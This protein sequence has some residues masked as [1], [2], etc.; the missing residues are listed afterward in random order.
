[1][2][3][4][5]ANRCRFFLIATAV[6]LL[7]LPLYG[8][9]Q[10]YAEDSRIADEFIVML[11]PGH[12]VDALMQDISKSPLAGNT[13]IEKC[14]SPRM[15]IYH[16]KRATTAASE[17]FLLLLM[18][19]PHIKLAQYNHQVKQRSLIPNDPQFGSQWNMLNTAQSANSIAGDDID[20]TQA[21]ELNH[22]N[23]DANGDTV[24]VAVIDYLFDTGHEDLNF[25]I[26]HN[27]I[28]G[29]GIDDDGNGYIDDINGWNVFTQNGDVT[30]AGNHSTHCAGIVG[31]I[32]DNNLGI[33]GVCWGAKILA[34]AGT[35]TT[36]APVVEAYD[37][38]RNMRLLYN[39][40]FGTKGAY[41][42]ATN[43]SFGVDAG[44]PADFPIWCAMY[45]SMGAVGIISATA[46]SNGFVDVDDV[47]DI[48]TQCPS[49]WMI[50]VTNTNKSDIK[51]A[52]YGRNSIDIGAPGS[53]IRSTIP[54]SNYSSLS[55]TSMAAPHVAGTVAAMF[56]A[57]CKSFI[58]KYREYPDSFALQVK[59]YL[60]Q[61]AEWNSTLNNKS[62]TGGRLN[63]FRSVSLLKQ[64]DCDSCGFTANLNVTPIT[65]KNEDDG[66]AEITVNNRSTTSFSVLWSDSLTTATR[67]LLTPG[68]YTA[69]VTDTVTGCTRVV[70]GAYHNPDSIVI[71][72]L[73]AS[74]PGDGAP[75][76][77]VVQATASNEVLMYSIDG[78]NYQP[79]SVF[80]VADTGTY[81]VYIKNSSGCI[82]E[83]TITVRITG[84]NELEDA[85][86][87]FQLYPNPT[88]NLVTLYFSNPKTLVEVFDLTGRKV[89]ET[90]P[91]AEKTIINTQLW[92]NGVYLV[93]AAGVERKLIVVH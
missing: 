8:Q 47:G 49:K 4:L 35:A 92:Q 23:V 31:A 90:I 27:E 58:D 9:A 71:I 5:F 53:D 84:L 65:C 11:K 68:F 22:D 1:M 2:I 61:G 91:V 41:V 40:T 76:T 88:E 16:L 83:R 93:K 17:E 44:M 87:S 10:T 70:A 82:L 69:S 89:F 28:G 78:I 51:T 21:W 18:Q 6:Y 38:V 57:A 80:S 48:P 60:L 81:N 24:V 33:A 59:D 32:G 26:N 75:G 14:L 52:G 7:L 30:G 3:A 19:N 50:T 20:A 25:F 86:N 34:V 37:Y 85:A 72:S 36:E 29:N 42:V 46:T 67:Q 56:S 55:G 54:Q 15:G 63:L 77:I 74:A 73:L 79:T 64:F 39:N 12:N 66:M 62:T 43:S 45:D 13:K